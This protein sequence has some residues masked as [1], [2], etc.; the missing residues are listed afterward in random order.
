ML[1]ASDCT[2]EMTETQ[3]TALLSLGRQGRGGTK[4]W[5]FPLFI[6]LLSLSYISSF[7]SIMHKQTFKRGPAMNLGPLD[8]TFLQSCI[9]FRLNFL[10]RDLSM[11]PSINTTASS[12]RS[13]RSVGTRLR[14][15]LKSRVTLSASQ[16]RVS[17]PTQKTCEPQAYVPRYVRVLYTYMYL[18]VDIWQRYNKCTLLYPSKKG[19]LVTTTTM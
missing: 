13:A 3:H 15:A 10:T 1:F 9:L 12:R 5:D 11:R 14:C 8:R 18:I 2:K 19:D 17:N 4:H 7:L 6:S 16:K